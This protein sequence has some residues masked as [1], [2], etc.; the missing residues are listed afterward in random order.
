[1]VNQD[2]PITTNSIVLLE[3]G[4]RKIVRE[5]ETGFY[6]I[7]AYTGR[8]T[9]KEDAQ[10]ILQLL[11]R[12]NAHLSKVL[13]RRE[14]PGLISMDAITLLTNGL[15]VLISQIAIVVKNLHDASDAITERNFFDYIKIG[16]FDNEITARAWLSADVRKGQLS[17]YEGYQCRVLE[18][19]DRLLFV[20]IFP[21]V[22]LAVDELHEILNAVYRL[23]AKPTQVLI[24]RPASV[25]L[26]RDTISLLS[27]MFREKSIS[28]AMV[29]PSR[30]AFISARNQLAMTQQH[31]IEVFTCEND[32]RKWLNK[33]HR[34]I[35]IIN[36]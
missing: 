30:A 9:T 31:D 2:F 10:N 12:D 14:G 28:V 6:V 4:D 36:S 29:V 24:M 35:P 11:L 5:T 27:E 33:R 7:N 16:V 1:M 17:L 23:G 13:I 18:E 20:D 26:A 19:E 21:G 34:K 8:T 15:E 3:T 25:A 32:A 22:E